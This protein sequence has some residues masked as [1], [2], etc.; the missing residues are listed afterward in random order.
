[1]YPTLHNG[2]IVSCTKDIST[3]EKGDIIVFTTEEKRLIKRVIAIPGDTIAIENGKVIVNGSISEY[4]YDDIEDAGI[5]ANGTEI[6]LDEDEYFCLGD[7]RNHSSDCRE[8]GPI[9]KKQ[10]QRKIKNILF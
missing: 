7:N 5:L 6:F 10:I 8:F 4:N 1:M 2:N 9:T 3:I